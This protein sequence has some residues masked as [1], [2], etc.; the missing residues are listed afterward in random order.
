M[1]LDFLYRNFWLKLVA[2]L[3]AAVIWIV[4]SGERRER[5]LERAFE[6][7]LALVGVPR[8]LVITSQL[9]DAIDVRLRGPVSK[10]RSL[11]SQNLE[12]TLDMS[13]LKAGEAS[14][15][16]RPDTL[17]L[18]PGVEVVSIDPSHIRIRLE[19]RRQKMV[20]IRPYLVGAIPDGFEIG[21]ID[22]APR[23]ALISGPGSTIRETTE[24]ATE[25]L[26]LSGRSN[27][28][29]VRVGLIADSPLVRV[30]EPLS[31]LVTIEVRQQAL[32]SP[33]TEPPATPE[34][35]PAR[36]PGGKRSQ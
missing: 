9:Q 12:S 1:R 11:S 16:I 31:A 27:T 26:I 17:N 24:V 30:V 36:K 5:V 35:S 4:V 18:P 28:F 33:P 15:P 29:S 25:R 2:V 6:V 14:V 8:D 22:V 10:L 20:P 3:F 23:M 32:N 21:T 13:E 7:P 34:K 19:A